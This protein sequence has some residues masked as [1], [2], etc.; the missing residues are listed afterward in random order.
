M[1]FITTHSIAAGD[2]GKARDEEQTNRVRFGGKGEKRRNV[3]CSIEKGD[4]VE[5]KAGMIL[6]IRSSVTRFT[7]Q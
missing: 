5:S 6:G 1:Q 7:N 2:N 3:C 4:I